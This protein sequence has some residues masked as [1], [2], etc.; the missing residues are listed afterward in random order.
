MYST[1]T[2]Y[3]LTKQCIMTDV[4]TNTTKE[5]G[6]NQEADSIVVDVEQTV[7]AEEE[8]SS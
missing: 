6:L 2:Q 7:P 1:K 3:D 4:A 5:D 8:V